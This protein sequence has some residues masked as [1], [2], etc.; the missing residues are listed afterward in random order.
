MKSGSDVL[1]EHNRSDMHSVVLEGRRRSL[2]YNGMAEDMLPK[3]DH[4]I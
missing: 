4:C 2:L 3:A 1:N